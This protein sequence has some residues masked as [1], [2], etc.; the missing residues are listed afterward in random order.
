MN[1]V[2]IFAAIYDISVMFKQIAAA[3]LLMAIVVQTFNKAVIVT[4]YYANTGAYAKDCINK[5]KPKLHCNGKCQ[6][7]KKM[8]QEEKKDEGNGLTK[9]SQDEVI[10][11]KC[12]FA[13]IHSTEKNIFTSFPSYIAGSPID[14]ASDFFHPPGA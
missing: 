8:N 14:T 9:A 6:M 11:S 4:S 12:F 1:A 10:S 5:A 13:S 7:L 3:I 2:Y